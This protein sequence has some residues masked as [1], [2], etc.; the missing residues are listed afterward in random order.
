MRVLTWLVA[1][2]APALL[3]GCGKPGVKLYPVAGVVMVGDR[4]VTSGTIQFRADAA[5]G[6]KTMEVP[7]GE[8]Q[9]DGRFELR[10]AERLGAP[11]G[12]YRVVVVGDNFQVVDPPPGP[13]WPDYP[14][15][16]LKKPL[17]NER[18]LY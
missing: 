14:P 12:W 4:A 2:V 5:K 18:Y 7:V 1:A 6:N 17:V 9:S 13:H 16:F 3:C 8:I 15:G 10:T 11:P